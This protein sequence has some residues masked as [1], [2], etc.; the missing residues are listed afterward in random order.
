MDHEPIGY[1][2]DKLTTL[3]VYITET[4]LRAD[5]ECINVGGETDLWTIYKD[6]QVP[7]A[8]GCPEHYKEIGLAYVNGAIQGEVLVNLRNAVREAA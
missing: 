2:L 3:Y 8:A 6:G 4:S 5:I 1:E 7:R